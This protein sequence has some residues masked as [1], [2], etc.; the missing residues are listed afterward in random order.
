M[1]AFIFS[2]GLILGSLSNHIVEPDCQLRELD[3][4][5]TETLLRCN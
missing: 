5:K 4:P 1:V 3:N 2:W